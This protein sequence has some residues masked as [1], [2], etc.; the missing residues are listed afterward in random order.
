MVDGSTLIDAVDASVSSVRTRSLDISFNELV[1]MYEAGEMVIDPEFQRLFR[2]TAGAQS[3][4]IESL[5]LELPLPPIYLLEAEDGTYELI[6]GLQ[7]ISSYLA[8][9]GRLKIDGK[10]RDPLVLQ[11]CDIVRELN[12]LRYD[13]LPKPVEIKLKRNFVRAEILRRESDRRL[14]YYMFKRLNTGG[15]ALEQQELRNCTIRLLSATF[16]NLLIELSKD[17]NFRFCISTVAT[18]QIQR[19]YDQELVLR[20]FAFKNKA[21][22]YR[23]EIGDFLTEYMEAVSD[24][25]TEELFDYAAETECFRKTFA[26]LAAAAKATPDLG[27]RLFGSVVQQQVRGQFA[28][29]QFEGLSLGVQPSL[30]ALDP[31]DADQMGRLGA[32]LLNVKRDPSFLQHTGGGKNDAIPLKGRIGVAAASITEFVNS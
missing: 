26:V 29:H 32:T 10:V 22:D 30:S 27:E 25:E 21:D 9:R 13:E 17:E 28:V 6:D 31:E 3:R 24:E 20:F 8:F 5:I 23:H 12:G 1:D 15:E 4:L 2:W 14:R 18:S 19:K 11:D 7:R 16:N